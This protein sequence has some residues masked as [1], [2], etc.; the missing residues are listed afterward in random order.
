MLFS[1]IIPPSPSP[2]ES[3]TLFYT[4]V[5][6]LLSHIYGHHKG[7]FIEVLSQSSLQYHL[8]FQHIPMPPHTGTLSCP[9]LGFLEDWPCCFLLLEDWPCCSLLCAYGENAQLLLQGSAYSGPGSISGPSGKAFPGWLSRP[10]TLPATPHNPGLQPKW[11]IQN[12][13]AQALYHLIS[14]LLSMDWVCSPPFTL[15]HPAYL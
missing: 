7:A 9:S 12:S 8:L 2:T 5:S 4:S 14:H 15:T 10:A 13:L 6:L 3:K 1:Q 11:L